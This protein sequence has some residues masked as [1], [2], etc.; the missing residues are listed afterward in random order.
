V[1]IPRWKYKST[2]L[3]D[4]PEC[5]EPPLLSQEGKAREARWGGSKAE[6][7][8][9]G[10]HPSRDPLCDPAALLT[11]EGNVSHVQV[12]PNFQLHPNINSAL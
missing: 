8:R 4:E 12:T 11:Q 6:M 5:R 3:G 2:G 1:T 9:D 7:F 10:N